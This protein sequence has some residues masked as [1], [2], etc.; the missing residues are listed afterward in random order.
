MPSFRDKLIEEFGLKEG[1]RILSAR[2]KIAASKRTTFNHN[3]PFKDPE[4][5]RKAQLRSA[6]VRKENNAKVKDFLKSQ[7]SVKE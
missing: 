7:D 3:G 2:N 6:Q 4:F 1:L 5:A